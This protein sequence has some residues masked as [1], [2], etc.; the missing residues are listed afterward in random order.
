MDT[1]W[2]EKSL[3]CR[4]W[5][6]IDSQKTHSVP[7]LV[8]IITVETV[9]GVA[10]RTGSTLNTICCLY[11]HV[12]TETDTRGT[13]WFH[14][15]SPTQALKNQTTTEEKSQFYFGVLKVL[16]IVHRR[17][18]WVMW[19]FIG[20]RLTAGLTL[21]DGVSE[22]WSLFDL[23]KPKQKHSCIESGK[24]S[25]RSGVRWQG[26]SGLRGTVSC[27]YLLNEDVFQLIYHLC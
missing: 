13:L 15:L 27:L 24:L 25:G 10:I 8:H 19:L 23:Q 14:H 26:L 12:V 16:M 20:A 2:K 6:H 7:Y 3:M 22:K 9:P 11:T 21:W 5:T 17:V 4:S 18:W 1:L